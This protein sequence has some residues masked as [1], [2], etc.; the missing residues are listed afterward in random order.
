[1]FWDYFKKDAKRQA[2]ADPVWK[3]ERMILYGTDG[4]LLDREELA[5]YLPQLRIPED[6]RAFLELLVWNKPF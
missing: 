6:R 1:M 2:Q 4:Q 5:A 3:L